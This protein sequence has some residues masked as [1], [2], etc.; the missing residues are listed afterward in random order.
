MSI[1]V[2]DLEN[3]FIFSFY[4]S[5]VFPKLGQTILCF[6]LSLMV[7]TLLKTTGHMFFK[8]AFSVSLPNAFS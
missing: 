2:E 4:V 8:V 6:S 3:H 1:S 7:L 5:L